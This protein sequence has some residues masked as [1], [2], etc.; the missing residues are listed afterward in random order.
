MTL[1]DIYLILID[2]TKWA[3]NDSSVTMVQAH[4]T[5]PRA[6]KPFITL[7]IGNFTQRGL[8]IEYEIDDNGIQRLVLHKKL[9]LTWTSFSDDLH[10]AEELL[11]LVKDRLYT[12]QARREYFKGDI[13]PKNILMGVQPMPKD[14]SSVTESQAVLDVEFGF[15]SEVFDDVGLIETIIVDNKIDDTQIIVSK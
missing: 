5:A 10:Q 9:V 15:C 12:E 13:V 1:S 3:V 4:Q 6:K 2:Y 11:I 14:I 8:P 7:S